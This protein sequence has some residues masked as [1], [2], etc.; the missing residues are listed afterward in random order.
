MSDDKISREEAQAEIDG[1]LVAEI[2]RDFGTNFYN[3]YPEHILAR[4]VGPEQSFIGLAIKRGHLV[5]RD[6]AV[7]AALTEVQAL[8]AAAVME[9][10]EAVEA[11]FPGTLYASNRTKTLVTIR[12]L[13]TPDAKAALEAHTAREVAKA[14]EGAAAL[15]DDYEHRWN[16]TAYDRRQAGKDDNFAYA[17]AS[18]SMHIAIAI[19]A[20]ITPDAMAAL[21]A[22][23]AREV[24]KALE[25][26]VEAVHAADSLELALHGGAAIVDRIRALIPEVKP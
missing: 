23:T 15:A 24:A 11:N 3:V 18:A 20:L 9:A 10:A 13:I 22:H 2:C 1:L 5:R 16:A 6:P 26:A 19:R 12:A 25:G 8:V 14:L 21:E 17:S 7:L 4:G